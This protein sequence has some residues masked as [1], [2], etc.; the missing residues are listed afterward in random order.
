MT[1]TLT[2]TVDGQPVP[3]TRRTFTNRATGRPVAVLTANSK[4]YQA[5]VAAVAFRAANKSGYVLPEK[6][7]PMKVTIQMFWRYPKA[8][9]VGDRQRLAGAYKV[10]KPDTSN[11]LKNVEDAISHTNGPDGAGA[12][13]FHDDEAI[14]ATYIR[15]KLWC[16]PGEER[17]EVTVEIMPPLKFDMLSGAG[18]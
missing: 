14:V 18:E 9:R 16:H 12:I 6:G 10:T 17:V 8:T 11:V 1:T 2:F 15:P 13:A 7:T 4:K 3:Q 5:Y